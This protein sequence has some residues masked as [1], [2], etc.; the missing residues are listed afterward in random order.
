[1]TAVGY[2]RVSTTGQTLDVQLDM[3]KAAGCERIYSEKKSGLDGKRSELAKCLDYVREGD[4]LLVT[5][6][7]RLA[8]STSDLYGIVGRLKEKGVGFRCLDNRELDTTTKTGKLMLGILALIAEFEADIRKE[9]QLE[10]IAKAKERGVSFGRQPKLSNEQVAELRKRRKEGEL[11]RE[12]MSDYSLSKATV[13]RL[14]GEVA[15]DAA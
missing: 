3:L 1:M 12:L 7:D 9:R 6:L 11:I 14:L 2:A 4:T 13:Y 8:R 15:A 10:G 5:K